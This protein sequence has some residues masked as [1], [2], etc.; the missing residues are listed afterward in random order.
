MKTKLTLEDVEFELCV[1]PED[2][3]FRNL[4]A[5]DEPE[6]DREYEEWIADELDNG[7]QWAWC[8]VIVFARFG[9]LEGWD[10]LGGC[11][12]KSQRD[13][14]QRGYYEDMR[15]AA[16]DHLQ[17]KCDALFAALNALQAKREHEEEADV[18]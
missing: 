15:L 1:E 2:T 14:E 17:S 12:Y 18:E 9:G 4:F 13:F 16:L 3:D 8:R 6:L 7:N 10:S 11:S 5:T